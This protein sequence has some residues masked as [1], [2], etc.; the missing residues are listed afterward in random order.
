M[1]FG[2][3]GNALILCGHWLLGRKS[4]V[5]FLFTITGGICWIIEG[6]HISKP[7]LIFIELVLGCIAIRN[8]F[9]W[10]KHD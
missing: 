9:K 10:A 3:L 7:D 8:F 4:R 1:T 5:A 6:L 2:W